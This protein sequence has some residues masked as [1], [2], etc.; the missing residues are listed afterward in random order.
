MEVGLTSW[1]THETTPTFDE[2]GAASG[3]VLYRTEVDLPAGGVLTVGAEVRDRVL[4][5]VDGRSVGVL[6]REH[7]DRAIALPPVTGTLELLVEDQGRV[8]YGT[9][10]GEPKG[11]I[12]G[13]TVDGVPTVQDDYRIAYL[14]DH[15]VQVREAIADGVDLRGYFAWSLMDNFEWARGYAQRFGLVHVDYETQRRTLKTSAHAYA[16]A[17]REHREAHG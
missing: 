3:F 17:I 9:R 12:G 4:V 2:L 6:E 1:T 7:H 8:D 14:N 10:I 15:L 5:S 16:D 13:V 11:L